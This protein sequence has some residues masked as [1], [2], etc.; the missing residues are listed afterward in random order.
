MK[1]TTLVLVTMAL[2]FE[3]I[4]FLWWLFFFC[5]GEGDFRGGRSLT[6]VGL[7]AINDF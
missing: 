1:T 7:M 2:F 4:G 3:L 5:G 6:T